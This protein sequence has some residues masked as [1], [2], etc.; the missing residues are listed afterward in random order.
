VFPYANEGG[1][2]SAAALSKLGYES[3][4]GSTVPAPRSSCT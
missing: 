4:G 1:D 2:L 3:G